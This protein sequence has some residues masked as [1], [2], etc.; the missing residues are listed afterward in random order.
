MKKPYFLLFMFALLYNTLLAQDISVNGKV[1]SATDN[2]PVPGVTVLVKGTTKGT[3]T[4]VNGHYSLQ[5]PSNGILIFSFIGMQTQEIAIDGK[6]QINVTMSD[7]EILICFCISP[8][9]HISNKDS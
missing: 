9:C 3:S 2:M 5:A 6:K 7:K 8:H 1:S 4:D